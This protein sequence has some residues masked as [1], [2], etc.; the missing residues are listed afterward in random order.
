MEL[1]DL[2]MEVRRFSSERDWEQFHTPKNLV[3]ALMGEVG[4]LAELF[5]WL[6]ES[7]TT[8]FLEDSGDADRVGEE[9]ADVFYYLLRLA[10]VLGID[11]GTALIA[12]LEVNAMKYPVDKAKGSSAK[13]TE[14]PS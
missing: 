11:L 9:V 14:Y 8:A 5:Q 1:D 12:K 13:Y 7:Q 2:T 3:M 4:E 6:N 10:D